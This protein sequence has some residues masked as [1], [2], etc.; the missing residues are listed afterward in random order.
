MRSIL[1]SSIFG[2]RCFPFPHKDIILQNTYAIRLLHPPSNSFCPFL[3]TGMDSGLMITWISGYLFINSLRNPAW[4]S[5]A[6]VRKTYLISEKESKPSVLQVMI[7]LNKPMTILLS[8]QPWTFHICLSFYFRAY[9]A[10]NGS[11]SSR[12]TSSNQ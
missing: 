2:K 1:C 7:H 11:T 4:S 6:C 12:C 8:R 10:L 3:R 5:C 9:L